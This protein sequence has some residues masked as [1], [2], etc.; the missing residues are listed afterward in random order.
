MPTCPLHE[1]AGN[2]KNDKA[3]RDGLK[4][5]KRNTKSDNKVPFCVGRAFKE[6]N[7]CIRMDSEVPSV[8]LSHVP[9]S[10][11]S[12]SPSLTPSVTLSS[13]PSSAPS[14]SS[15]TDPSSVPSVLP[16]SM[17]SSLP[18]QKPSISLSPS[19]NPSSSPSC[20]GGLNNGRINNVNPGPNGMDCPLHECVGS[21]TTNS[22]REG[23]FCLK[24]T[25]GDSRIVPGC[26][27]LAFETNNYCIKTPSDVPSVSSSNDP[28]S[29][30]STA[31]S[32]TASDNP[33]SKPSC[34][35]GK[36][37]GNLENIGDGICPLNE[38]TGDCDED[39]D[40]K[41]GLNCFQRSGNDIKI[42]PGCKGE[43]EKEIDYCIE[44]DNSSLP[45]AS[46]S[47]LPSNDSSA[48]PSV[49]PS[50][51]PSVTSSVAPSV[52]HPPSSMPSY[53]L[54]GTIRF[55]S[56]WRRDYCLQPK[57]NAQMGTGLCDLDNQHSYPNQQFYVGDSG[58]VLSSANDK[59]LMKRY[60]DTDFD[61]LV[62]QSCEEGGAED[63]IFYLSF[64]DKIIMGSTSE[65]LKAMY[66]DAKKD[67]A[68]VFF[69]KI[70]SIDPVK[71]SLWR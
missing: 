16:T 48:L 19:A 49:V 57:T 15:S 27:G 30:P 1:C 37:D 28:S 66:L 36:G 67:N 10:L 56:Q 20:Y 18:T 40:C 53:D 32:V 45:S 54:S 29:V 14:I 69:S 43:P 34:Y 12:S 6:V 22:C 24:R 4:C 13:M 68:L 50:V 41:S 58:E 51:L 62:L 55:V 25:K 64:N 7:Y 26:N 2:C 21:C 63:K 33:T 42:V 59:C 3:C 17:P 9:S 46:P 38:C 61:N 60:G 5:F 8:T 35:G 11:P 23:L 39:S 52:T 47:I 65:N 44:R 71:K 31:P 70:S